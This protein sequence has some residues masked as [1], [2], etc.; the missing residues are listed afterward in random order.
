MKSLNAVK[1][2]FNSKSKILFFFFRFFIVMVCVGLAASTLG[3]IHSVKKGE[4]LFKKSYP[5]YTVLDDEYEEYIQEEEKAESLKNGQEFISK[6]ESDENIEVYPSYYDAVDLKGSSKD[7]LADGVYNLH[8]FLYLNGNSIGFYDLKVSDGR[9]FTSEDYN[10]EKD[11]KV[12]VIL[13][14]DFKEFY[15]VDDDF[16]DKYTIVGFLEKNTYIDLP[17]GIGDYG[18]QIDTQYLD[19]R[20]IVPFNSRFESLDNYFSGV[21]KFKDKEKKEEVVSEIGRSGIASYNFALVESQFKDFYRDSYETFLAYGIPALVIAV[22]GIIGM[23]SYIL[24]VIGENK[25]IITQRLSESL[26]K[27]DIAKGI[28]YRV[29]SIIVAAII[30]ATIIFR[31]GFVGGILIGTGIVVIVIIFFILIRRVLRDVNL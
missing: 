15:K 13:G 4:G 28:V 27:K 12:P 8:Y 26:T 18:S 17:Q 31:S 10:Y 16:T 7:S 11:D 21:I 30:P 5:L 19:S 6:Y 3:E 2:L 9:N 14:N 24:T 29:A 22:F 25:D 20:I 23:V 1:G